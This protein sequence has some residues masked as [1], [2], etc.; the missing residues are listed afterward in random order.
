[1]SIV[2]AVHQYA[3]ERSEPAYAI[4]IRMDKVWVDIYKQPTEN[5]L[6][7]RLQKVKE[8]DSRQ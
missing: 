6:L 1:M 8:E 5:E 7:K 3:K 2:K 4:Y